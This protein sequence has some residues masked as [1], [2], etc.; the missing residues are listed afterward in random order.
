[1]WSIFTYT[2]DFQSQESF[3]G[4]IYLPVTISPTILDI[5]NRHLFTCHCCDT[6]YDKINLR[7]DRLVCL[8]MGVQSILA[9]KPWWQD[10]RQ[11]I[12]HIASKVKK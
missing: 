8:N 6:I 5:R 12:D 10:L 4:G 3:F 7:K 2:F 11:L 1:M 9:G